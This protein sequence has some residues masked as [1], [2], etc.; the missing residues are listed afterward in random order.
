MVQMAQQIFTGTVLEK[1]SNA[2]QNKNTPAARLMTFWHHI[3]CHQS[4]GWGKHHGKII[5]VEPAGF[6][7]I[8]FES[9]CLEHPLRGSIRTGTFPLPSQSLPF[10]HCVGEKEVLQQVNVFPFQIK[11]SHTWYQNCINYRKQIEFLANGIC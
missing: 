11:T 7:R 1:K 3:E 5:D 6:F 4:P 10:S 2:K 8:S 9:Y